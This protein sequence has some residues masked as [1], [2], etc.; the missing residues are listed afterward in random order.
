MGSGGYLALINGTEYVW[1]LETSDAITH[2][3]KGADFPQTLAP[4]QT[5]RVYIEFEQTLFTPRT[6]TGAHR[7]Y[8]LEGADD[9]AFDILI[10]DEPPRI[11]AKFDN[12]S[13]PGNPDG[14]GFDLGWVHDGSVNSILSGKQGYFSSNNAPVDWMQ[15]SLRK[16]GSRPLSQLCFPGTHEAGM[17]WDALID[18]SLSPTEFTPWTLRQSRNVY[19]QLLD[20]SRYLDIRPVI[21]DGHLLTGKFHLYHQSFRFGGCGQ[22]I[23]EIV[24]DINRFTAAHKELVLVNLS[25]AVN[26]DARYRDLNQEEWNTVFEHFSRVHDRFVVSCAEEARCLTKQP[27][28]RFIGQGRAA[29]VVMVNAPGIR[30][31]KYEQGFFAPSNVG[32]RYEGLKTHDWVEMSQGQLSKLDILNSTADPRLYR[33]SWILSPE[34]SEIVSGAGALEVVANGACVKSTPKALAYSANKALFTECLPRCH[35]KNIPNILFVDY[36]EG[37]DLAALAMAINDRCFP[38]TKPRL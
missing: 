18:S 15:K 32:V 22:G 4:G 10:T 16:I 8:I 9:C 19:G 3:I 28:N 31:G 7:R 2:Q 17:S 33:L 21:V 34:I 29:V 12:F 24:N 35:A 6:D 1:R 5:S 14:V 30:F 37:R 26:V 25:H 38:I 13:T 20:G 27:L 11:R 36:L 23:S